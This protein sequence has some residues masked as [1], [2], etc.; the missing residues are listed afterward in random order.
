MD[1]ESKEALDAFGKAVVQEVY[2]RACSHLLAV[3]SRGMKGSRPDPLNLAYTS[4]DTA[5]AAVLREFLTH[6]VD[7]TFAQFLA[8]F[9]RH[10]IPIHFPSQNGSMVDVSAASDGLHAEPYNDDGWICRYSSFP[11]GIPS[12]K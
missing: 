4:L 11:D 3:I 6:A 9:D 12:P 2:D 1:R 5:T 10:E 7:Q 8:F